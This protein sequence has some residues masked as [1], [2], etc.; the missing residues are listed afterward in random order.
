MASGDAQLLTSELT[1]LE[2]LV[3]PIRGKDQQSLD[4]FDRVFDESG[5]QLLPVNRAVLRFASEL[6]ATH[7]NLRTPDAIHLASAEIYAA[8]SIITNDKRM[9][10]KTGVVVIVLSDLIQGVS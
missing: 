10:G 6:R 7:T 4:A 9:G 1:I 5:L 2:S 3:L 8:Q